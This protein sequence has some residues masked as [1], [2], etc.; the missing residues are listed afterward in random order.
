VIKMKMI[1]TKQANFYLVVGLIIA[2]VLLV[3]YLLIFFSQSGFFPG[4]VKQLEQWGILKVGL[5]EQ[6][7]LDI[8]EDLRNQLVKTTREYYNNDFTL[9]FKVKG[10]LSLDDCVVWGCSELPFEF[11][12]QI[13]YKE[14]MHDQTIYKKSEVIRYHVR[15]FEGEL[16]DKDIDEIE[17]LDEMSLMVLR[18]GT[19][20]SKESKRLKPEAKDYLDARVQLVRKEG[21]PIKINE[22]LVVMTLTRIEFLGFE[23]KTL[24][25]R[26]LNFKTELNQKE[27]ETGVRVKQVE[28]GGETGVKEGKEEDGETE[29]E[30]EGDEE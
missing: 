23:G 6:Q 17:S 5:T 30:G 8:S 22:K 24:T 1:R 12:E 27:E 21:Q 10:K 26:L 3:L 14:I 20:L 13:P 16:A 18:G 25:Y 15:G 11:E 19:V 7:Q 4:I 29:Q 28:K 2:S 9:V